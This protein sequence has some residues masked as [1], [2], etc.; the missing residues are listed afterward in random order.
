MEGGLQLD[1]EKE[2]FEELF[3]SHSG[4][5]TNEDLMILE[6]QSRAKKEQEEAAAQEVVLVKKFDSRLMA[7]VFT[8]I[9]K[10]LQLF[11][12]QDPNAE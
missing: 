2:D 7:E 9:E 8:L 10:G 12:N 6:E 3:D 4:E 1:L 11:E 5:L